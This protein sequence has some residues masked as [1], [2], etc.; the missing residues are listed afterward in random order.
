MTE[1][2][3]MADVSIATFNVLAAC[4]KREAVCQHDAGHGRGHRYRTEAH[5]PALYLPRLDALST[6]LASL[7]PPHSD[8]CD[9]VCLQEFWTSAPSDG[10]DDADGGRVVLVGFDHDR[11]LRSVV[12]RAVTRALPDHRGY[13]LPRPSSCF[14]IVG[15]S[16]D[17]VAIFVHR[18]LQV[19]DVASLDMGDCGRRCALLLRLE[20][21]AARDPAREPP[22]PS[23]P[24]RKRWLLCVNTHLT[25]PHGMI[26]GWMRRGQVRKLLAWIDDYVARGRASHTDNPCGWFDAADTLDV[27]LAGDFNG[28]LTDA[29]VRQV[30]EARYTPLYP[31]AHDGRAMLVSHRDHHS[32]LVA[33][34]HLFLRRFD[35]RQAPVRV[36]TATDSAEQR[37][38][39]EWCE[40]FPLDEPDD[41]SWPVEFTVS[42]HRPVVAALRFRSLIEDSSR[43]LSRT[44]DCVSPRL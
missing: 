21:P 26:D 1:V 3:L 40:L 44:A 38:C 20:L 12:T 27:V 9:L 42:D 24:S 28:D 41:G 7:H 2:V 36:T 11:E 37:L 25:F 31:E 5:D 6:L 32:R 29:A 22:S 18:R 34:D 33:V 35:H 13:V 39:V 17:G 19:A 43:Q 30:L 15:R 23:S 14:P 16:E 4:Y 8:A 10:D